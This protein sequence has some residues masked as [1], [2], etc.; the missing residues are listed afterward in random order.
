MTHNRRTA[1]VRRRS[2]LGSAGGL[3]D[4]GYAAIAAA[5]GAEALEVA[6]REQPNLV[7]MDVMMPVLDGPTAFRHM[8]DTPELQHVPVVL[9]SAADPRPLD[10]RLSG[11]VA[12]PFD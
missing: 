7:L 6:T 2:W 5:N 9:M 4:E 3:E 12:K 1:V 11:F 8:R 10:A